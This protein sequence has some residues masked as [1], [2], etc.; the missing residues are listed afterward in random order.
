MAE[1]TPQDFFDSQNPPAAAPPPAPPKKERKKRS[2]RKPP[3]EAAP[4]A[5]VSPTNRRRK[6]KVPTNAPAKPRKERNKREPRAA[7][8]A[9][10]VA[11]SAL[12]GLKPDEAQMV[13]V[14]AGKLGAMPKRSR[15]RI[16]A[17][18]ARMFA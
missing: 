4:A 14:A 2:P 11:I 10:D 15:G 5:D 13:A 7:K 18:L 3:A 9:L 8:V 12:A 6:G 1:N 16:V 17:A